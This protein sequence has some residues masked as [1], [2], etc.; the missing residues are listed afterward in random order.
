MHGITAVALTNPYG[1]AVFS[2]LCRLKR[3]QLAEPSACKIALSAHVY[4]TFPPTAFRALAMLCA[5]KE[6]GL[7]N[8]ELQIVD[9]GIDWLPGLFA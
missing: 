6:N 4:S 9:Y 7:R 2:L 3:G 1:I 5:K 8:Y